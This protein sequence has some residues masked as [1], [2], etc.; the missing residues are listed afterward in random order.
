MKFFISN[1]AG[2]EELAWL[3]DMPTAFDEAHPQRRAEV[4]LSQRQTMGDRYYQLLVNRRHGST[5]VTQFIGTIPLSK[6][7]PHRHLYEEAMICLQGEGVVWTEKTKT[8]VGPGDVFFLP[9]KQ[10]H[11][12]QCTAPGGLDLVGVIYPGDNPS[13]NY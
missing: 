11:S 13:I 3:D 6:A 8:T 1:G 7:E 4:D 12:V 5:I 10:V 9:R 2:S